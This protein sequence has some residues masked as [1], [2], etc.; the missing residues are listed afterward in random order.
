MPKRKAESLAQV[1]AVNVSKK[2]KHG[3]ATEKIKLN[4][5]DD[6]D[7]PSSSDDDSVGG[8][9]GIRKEI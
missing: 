4:L 3:A 5:L 1:P 2:V 6:S 9:R 8:Q 7:S